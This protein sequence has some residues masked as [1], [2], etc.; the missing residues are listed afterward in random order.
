[1]GYVLALLCAVTAGFSVTLGKLVLA[2]LSPLNYVF[3][4]MAL[5]VPLTA[6]LLPFEERRSGVS[7]RALLAL[8]AHVACVAGAMWSFWAGVK[9]IHPA[10]A[11]FVSRTETLV[12]VALAMWVLKERLGIRVIFGFL[13]VVAGLALMKLPL[14]QS[15]AVPDAG[16]WLVLLSSLGWGVAEV[17]SKIAV[18]KIPPI[19]FTAV[20]SAALTVIF[21]IVGAFQGSIHLPNSNDLLL[22]LVIAVIGPT[23]ARVFYMQ[24]LSR[25]ELSIVAILEQTQPIFAAALGLVLL[26]QIP[27][28]NEWVGG[29]AIVSGCVF[30]ILARHRTSIAEAGS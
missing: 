2:T 7:A 10:V 25:I 30:V 3:W 5:S 18:Y 14:G 19:A 13:I 1:M 6:L 15:K 29:F 11:S 27:G 21:G 12:T 20:R 28:M 9:T 8:G 17:F 23:L 24:A 26:G 22:L 16:F 4:M